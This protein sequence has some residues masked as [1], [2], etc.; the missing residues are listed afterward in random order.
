MM[1]GTNHIWFLPM[2]F[3]RFCFTRLLKE[4]EIPIYVKMSL[5]LILSLTSIMCSTYF[6]LNKAL[7]YLPF[8]YWG[9]EM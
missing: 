3:W 9:F 4:I 8:F 2:L 6:R 1:M 5:L 7:L